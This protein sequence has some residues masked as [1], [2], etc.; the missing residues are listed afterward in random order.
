MF[1]YAGVVISIIIF[2]LHRIY[3]LDKMQTAV[4]AHLDLICNYHLSQSNAVSYSTEG[5]LSHCLSIFFHRNS[6]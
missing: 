4:K 5:P 3:Y 6:E 1:F 2:R